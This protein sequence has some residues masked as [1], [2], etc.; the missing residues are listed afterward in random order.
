[1]IPPVSIASIAH[2]LFFAGILYFGDGAM[3]KSGIIGR[4][5]LYYNRHISKYYAIHIAVYLA[6]FGFHKYEGFSPLQC[7][8]YQVQHRMY[9]DKHKAHR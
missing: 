7:W 2:V 8:I 1:M 9:L 6:M 5:L 3:K 4:Q